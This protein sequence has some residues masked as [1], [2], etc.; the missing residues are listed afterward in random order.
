MKK[1]GK[2][3]NGRETTIT[4][5]VEDIILGCHFVIT[6]YSNSRHHLDF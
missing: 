2:G 5:L 4:A 1:R 3:L 6:S